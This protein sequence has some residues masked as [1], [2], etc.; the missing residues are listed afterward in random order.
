M[1]A[2]ENFER[3]DELTYPQRHD[4]TVT[5]TE[6][7]YASS[8]DNTEEVLKDRRDHT[9]HGEERRPCLVCREDTPPRQ[10]TTGSSK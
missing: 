2:S 7:L 9:Y 8:G 6:R 1:L 4:S 3:N 5:L 10:Q